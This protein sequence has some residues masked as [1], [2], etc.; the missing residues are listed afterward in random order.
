MKDNVD[1]GWRVIRDL[2]YDYLKF[3]TKS[4]E[5]LS[6]DDERDGIELMFLK[7]PFIFY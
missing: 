4:N 2:K 1:K 7:Q 3:S 5:I 6:I